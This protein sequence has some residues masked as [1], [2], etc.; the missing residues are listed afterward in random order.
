MTEIKPLGFLIPV[1]DKLYVTIEDKATQIG[2]IILTQDAHMRSQI[3]IVQAIGED[4]KGFEIGDRILISYGAGIHIQLPE[5]Y[6]FEDH[7]RIIRDI[8][9][10]A[11]LK[12][13]K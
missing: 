3:G 9:I 1:A 4:V 7:H 11:K 5:T 13:E 8:E 6:S 2:R 10:L 12:K